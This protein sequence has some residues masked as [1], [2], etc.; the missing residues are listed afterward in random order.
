MSVFD[1]LG[2]IRSAD[3]VVT[4]SFHGTALSILFGKDLYYIPDDPKTGERGTNL[5]EMLGIGDRVW[6]YN[7]EN[8]TSPIDFKSIYNVLDMEREKSA[9]FIKSALR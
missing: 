2:Y 1:F 4:S 7:G 5:L 6:N 9:D 3:F 8:K